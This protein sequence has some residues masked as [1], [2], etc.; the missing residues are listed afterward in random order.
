MLWNPGPVPTN[1]ADIFTGTNGPDSEP[2]LKENITL[3]RDGGGLV[4]FSPYRIEEGEQP[5][6][7][8][9]IVSGSATMAAAV[10]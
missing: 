5:C 10:R 3:R 4:L 8:G 1:G 9:R 6:G 2:V 7:R